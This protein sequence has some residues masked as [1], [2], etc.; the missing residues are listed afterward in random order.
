MKDPYVVL[1]V[2][3]NATDEEIKKA[4]RIL[5]KKYHPDNYADSDLA[6]LASEKMKEINEAY[7][8]IQ[9]ERSGQS[10]G[11]SYGG[12]YYTNTNAG[13]KYSQ[14]RVLIN[15][16]RVAEA[17]AMLGAVDPAERDAEWNFLMGCVM[18]QK[19]SFY[20]A[21]RYVDTACYMDPT[22]REYSNARD[23]MRTRTGSFGQPYT[24]FG[25]GN[26]ANACDCCSSLIC[27]DCCCEC[28]GGDLIPCC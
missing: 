12:S 16:R 18:M 27:A 10:T 17:E 24:T 13:G 23:Q 2:S 7:D 14:V 6:D 25:G 5:A 4:Y 3:R 8:T 22:N 26:G 21:Q 20:D 9:K 28:M 15:Q 11:S 1:G 19:G